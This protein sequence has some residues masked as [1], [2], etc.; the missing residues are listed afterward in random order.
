MPQLDAGDGDGQD[1]ENGSEGDADPTEDAH[2]GML[3]G[4]LR[5]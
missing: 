1:H 3:S 4:N 2:P 5:T